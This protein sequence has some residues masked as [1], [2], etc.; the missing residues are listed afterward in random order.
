MKAGTLSGRRQGVDARVTGGSRGG[1]SGRRRR[2]LGGR[3]GQE[4]QG[5]RAGSGSGGHSYTH[6]VV[7]QAAPGAEKERRGK[8]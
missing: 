6:D 8:N 2:A 5:R 7:T 3:R 4:R 1:G